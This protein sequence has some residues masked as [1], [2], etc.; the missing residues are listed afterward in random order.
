MCHC[1]CENNWKYR[2]C[3]M[4]I[5][6]YVCRHWCSIIQGNIA[7]CYIQTIESLNFDGKELQT[8]TIFIYFTGQILLLHRQFKDQG[9]RLPVSG[10]VAPLFPRIT[11]YFLLQ[12]H[13]PDLSRWQL[14]RGADRWVETLEKYAIPFRQCTTSY[15]HVIH[16]FHIWGLAKVNRRNYAKITIYIHCRP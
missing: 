4:S 2:S 7:W 14:W 1:G 9:R 8:S 12:R 5:T 16:R 15:A 6:V 13:I 11:I 10:L 3:Y